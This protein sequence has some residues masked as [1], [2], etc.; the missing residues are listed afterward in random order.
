MQK[1]LPINR[2]LAIGVTAVVLFALAVASVLLV[3]GTVSGSATPAEWPTLSMKYQISGTFYSISDAPA[4]TATKEILLE[5]RGVNDWKST[6]TNA[7]TITDG[8]L[9]FNETGSYMEVK[10]GYFNEY[11]ATG[12]GTRSEALEEGQ[13][14]APTLRMYPIPFDAMTERYDGEPVQKTVDVTVCLLDECEDSVQGWAFADGEEE[15]VYVDDARGIPVVIPGIEIT[16][17]RVTGE[18]Q[19][20]VR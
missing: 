16:E 4:E 10:D 13:L 1:S 9:E 8:T 11:D 17:V 19:P 15:Y 18:R 5:Y 7:P 6:I 2:T 20:V 14:M 3:W 12:G